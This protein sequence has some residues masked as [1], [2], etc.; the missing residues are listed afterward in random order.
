M[1]AAD[2]AAVVTW[3]VERAHEALADAQALLARGSAN[4][5]VNRAYYAVFYAA[6]AALL[7]EGLVLAKHAG[8]QGEVHRVLV[9]SGRVD[10]HWGRVYTRLFEDRLRCDY[11]DLV[12]FPLEDAEVLVNEARAF[13]AEMA[14]LLAETQAEA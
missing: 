12:E 5:A 7:R 9:Q 2:R 3:R 4:A 14:R 8:V 11:V 13:V 6:S 10:R 1:D